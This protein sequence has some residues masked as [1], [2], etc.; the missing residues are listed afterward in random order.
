MNV[1]KREIKSDQDLEKWKLTDAHNKLMN[2]LLLLDNSIKSKK[3]IIRDNVSETVLKLLNILNKTKQYLDETPIV[4]QKSCF[5]NHGFVNFYDKLVQNKDLIFKDLT[6]NLEVIEY[7]LTSFGNPI[8]I[9]LGTGNEMNFLSF[10]CCLFELQLISK[11]TIECENIVFQV[12][13]TYWDIIIEIQKKFRLAPAGTHGTWGVDDFVCL[14]FLFGSSQLIGNT[15]ILPSNV[16]QKEVAQKYSEENLY[17][18][19]IYYLHQ[20]KSGN[21]SQ[22]SRVLFS[23]TK[24]PDFDQ[25][26]SG[27]LKL[28]QSEVLDKFVVVQQFGF[29]SLLKWT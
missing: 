5:S 13:W 12:F 23:L 16:I 19:W 7:Y 6:T 22:H 24:V 10:I 26:H 17:C 25:I 14:P 4:E 11:D 18:K 27:M 2:T 20:C 1:L 3:R 21:F 8:R 28:F 15:D 9:D 29:G